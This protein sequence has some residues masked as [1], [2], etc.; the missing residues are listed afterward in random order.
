M[1]Q[2]HF[3]LKCGEYYCTHYGAGSGKVRR[4]CVLDMDGVL[5]QNDVEKEKDDLYLTLKYQTLNERA[6]TFLE[7]AKHKMKTIILTAR[8][9][10]LKGQIERTFGVPA[11]CRNFCLTVGEMKD[12]VASEQAEKAFLKQVIRWKID[13]LRDYVK[14]YYVIV[15]IDDHAAK[16]RQTFADAECY[17]FHPRELWE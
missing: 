7:Y 1:T 11:I 15:F 5:A 4:L 8:H 17:L 9:P 16:Y 2:C 3:P 6:L 10:D 13:V 14:R 12:A